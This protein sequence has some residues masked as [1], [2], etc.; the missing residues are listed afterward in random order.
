MKLLGEKK[1]EENQSETRM[2]NV[3]LSSKMEKIMR[4]SASLREKYK[5]EKALEAHMKNIQAKQLFATMPKES[6]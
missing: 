5:V 1:C 6:C 4:E 2:H 3:A